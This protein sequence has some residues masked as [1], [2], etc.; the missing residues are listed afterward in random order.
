MHRGVPYSPK[1]LSEGAIGLA[2]AVSK[3]LR[4]DHLIETSAGLGDGF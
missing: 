1:A 3:V 4:C 2:V